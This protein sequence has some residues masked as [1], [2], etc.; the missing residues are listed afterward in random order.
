MYDKFSFK[1]GS[2]GATLELSGE[3]QNY[4]SLAF[5]SDVFRSKT[6]ELSKFSVSNI[7]LTK[8]GTVTFSITMTFKPDF[9]LYTKNVGDQG[10]T[11]TKTTT[12]VINAPVSET[13]ATTT[14]PSP[15]I[16][17]KQGVL[18]ET[19]PVTSDIT[20]GLSNSSTTPPISGVSTTNAPGATSTPSALMKLWSRFKFW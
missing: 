7:A 16:T 9:L 12:P 4:A 11:E 5:Q 10:V 1:K 18:G 19:S 20:D 6:N 8:F 14:P 13:Q 17:S 15:E 3:A 2:D